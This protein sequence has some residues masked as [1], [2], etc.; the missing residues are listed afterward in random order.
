[1][2]T[3]AAGGHKNVEPL[4][5]KMEKYVL[6]E[7]ATYFYLLGCDA[8]DTSYKLLKLD[9]CVKQPKTLSDVL[10]EDPNIY[11]KDEMTEMLKMINEGNKTS[12]GLTQM[13]TGFGIVGF[14]RFLDCFYFTLITQRKKVG[15][16]ANND[17]YAIKAAEVFAIRPRE[18]ME[19]SL[20]N[21]WN[22]MKGKI[23][24]TT[25]D[26]AESRYM[27]LFQFIDISKD[28]FFSYTYDLTHSF[29]FN[30]NANHCSFPP[31]P[32]QVCFLSSTFILKSLDLDG[33]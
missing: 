25:V 29:Q 12:G 6:F 18:K 7:T 4:I 28:F 27:G 10:L 15:C 14:V 5:S 2:L 26:T 9:R 24:R 8:L 19:F 17:I 33:F 30:Y 1:M 13:A 16:I 21:V 23:N 20:K 3:A 32:H 11:T 31:P 22:N